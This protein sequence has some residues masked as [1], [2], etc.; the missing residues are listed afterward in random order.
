MKGSFHK[1]VCLIYSDAKLNVVFAVQGC[2]RVPR[3]AGLPSM[4]LGGPLLPSKDPRARR[5][6]GGDEF[7]E[8]MTLELGQESQ[9]T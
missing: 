1:I 9:R 5:P 4:E 8:E 7:T 6:V 2:P 3:G